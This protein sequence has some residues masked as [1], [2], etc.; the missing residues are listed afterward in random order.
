MV[1]HA[2]VLMSIHARYLKY[3]SDDSYMIFLQVPDYQG[4]STESPARCTHPLNTDASLTGN[5]L[6][7]TTCQ[8]CIRNSVRARKPCNPNTVRL[9][10]NFRSVLPR[11]IRVLRARSRNLTANARATPAPPVR[12]NLRCSKTPFYTTR[13][14]HRKIILWVLAD[15]Q[16]RPLLL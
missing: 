7:N 15:L 13:I 9:V 16:I 12:A 14:Y 1:T 3:I 11:A 5:V 4:A 2:C 8:V 10:L 6:Y